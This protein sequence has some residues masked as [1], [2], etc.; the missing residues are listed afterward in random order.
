MNEYS[1]LDKALFLRGML[2]D[3][4]TGNETQTELYIPIRFDLLKEP[5]ARELL[6]KF[7]VE[8]R[9]LKQFWHFIRYRFDHYAERRS[10]IYDA[11]QPLVS[12]LEFE[13]LDSGS[14]LKDVVAAILDKPDIGQVHELWA[15]ALERR[16]ED[17]EGA[18]TAARSLLEGVCK[19]ILENLDL[20][21]N[22]KWDLP[23]L[24]NKV[25]E[26]LNLAPSQHTEQ[27]FR[28]ILGGC[29][30]V[31]EGLG[32]LRNKLGDAHGKG[33]SAVRP[34]KRHAELA[35]NLSGTMASF[36]VETW[37]HRVAG[38]DKNLRQ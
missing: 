1:L 24:Y 30:S 33:R 3:F 13:E 8:C 32:G 15:K 17:P 36:L 2:I 9:D 28:Q 20:E 21:V 23:K 22:E 18:I 34:S 27:V 19:S 38:E 5:R 37:E 12:R 29:T 10:F 7:V 16:I 11:F 14:P 25:S 4:A 31:V 6:P 26:Q 35:V